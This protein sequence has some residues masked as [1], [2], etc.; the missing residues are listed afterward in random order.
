MNIKVIPSISTKELLSKSALGTKS[1]QKR[2]NLC[3]FS[4][5]IFETIYCMMYFISIFRNQSI[6]YYLLQYLS[7]SV[8]LSSVEI[9]SFCGN[10][11]SNSLIDLKIGLNVCEGVVHVQKV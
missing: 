1:T 7:S 8:R 10:S 11:L 9:I 6:Q 3:N 2:T 5:I 4:K